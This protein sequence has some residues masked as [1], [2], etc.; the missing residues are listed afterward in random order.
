MKT[1]ITIICIFFTC[2]LLAQNTWFKFVPGG[3]SRNNAI[4]NGKTDKGFE[5]ANFIQTPDKGFLLSGKYRSQWIKSPQEFN[6]F[7]TAALLKLDS[8]GCLQLGCNAKD[9]IIK[10]VAPDSKC[11]VFPNPATNKI[12]IEFEC[13]VPKNITANIYDSKGSLIK[14]ETLKNN[15][16]D[17]LDLH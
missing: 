7:Q 17:I 5:L 15:E 2:T 10:V 3:Y 14:S 4:L 12:N 8:N 16:I 6:I 13:I 11:T 9:K 1:L